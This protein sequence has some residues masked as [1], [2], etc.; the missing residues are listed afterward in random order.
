MNQQIRNEGYIEMIKSRRNMR[1]L[2][3][4]P[5]GFNPNNE[6]KIQ[7]LLEACDQY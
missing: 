1:I 7:M 5:R 6:S 2:T 3:M 4:N